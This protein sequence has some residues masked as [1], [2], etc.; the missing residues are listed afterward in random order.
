MN[1]NQQ[2]YVDLISTDGSLKHIPAYLVDEMQ[3]KGWR[4]VHN[5]K[6]TYY[7]EYDTTSPHYKKEQEVSEDSDMLQVT[8]L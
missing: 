7:P 6:R 1:Q 8:I 5:P 2:A 3:K 4:I